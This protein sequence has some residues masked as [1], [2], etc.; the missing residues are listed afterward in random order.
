VL[1]WPR[2]SRTVP[3][4]DVTRI[5]V[6]F[7]APLV[8]SHFVLRNPVLFLRCKQST[9]DMDRTMIEECKKQPKRAGQPPEHTVDAPTLLSRSGVGKM[10]SVKFICTLAV[11]RGGGT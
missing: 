5:R 6:Q 7:L 4:A 8:Q 2:G 10:R 11:D 3:L 9:V 1:L